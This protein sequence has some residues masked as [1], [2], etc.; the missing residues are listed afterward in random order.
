MDTKREEYNKYMREYMKK[1]YYKRKKEAFEYLGGKCAACGATSNL[2]IDH[3][4]PESKS[5]TVTSCLGS[6][7]KEKL[8]KELEKCQLLCRRCHRRKSMVD[9]SRNHG[10]TDGENSHLSKMTEEQVLQI[11]SLF[12][13][14]EMTQ[15]ALAEKF[16]M[17]RNGIADII[18]RRTWKHI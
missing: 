6:L 3:V 9:G 12:E 11:R 5:F 17:S 7:P 10:K 15:V 4:D 14:G 2:Q 18:A 13:S 16:G 1:R 8:W